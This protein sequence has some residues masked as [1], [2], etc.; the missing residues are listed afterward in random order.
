MNDFR[1]LHVSRSSPERKHA[2]L[3]CR[4]LL[5]DIQSEL[6]EV[7][8]PLRLCLAIHASSMRDSLAAEDVVH[9]C[10]LV[11]ALF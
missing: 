2:L 11:R 7:L 10:L 8:L 1:C 5:L 9:E 3:Q 4:V 6:H